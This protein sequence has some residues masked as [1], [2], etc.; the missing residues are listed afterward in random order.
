[1]NLKSWCNISGMKMNNAKLFTLTL[2]ISIIW[3]SGAIADQ[4]IKSSSLSEPKA[5]KLTSNKLNNNNRDIYIDSEDDFEGSGGRKGEVHDAL[6]NE[7]DDVDGS[8]SGDGFPGDDEDGFKPKDKNIKPDYNTNQPHHSGDGSDHGVDNDD[9]EEEEINRKKIIED[10]KPP[11]P[12]EKSDDIFFETSTETDTYPSQT[13]DEDSGTND[14]SRKTGFEYPDKKPDYEIDP[15]HRVPVSPT[16]SSSGSSDNVLIMNTSN[17]DRTT[18]FFAQPGI[19]AAVIGGAV[20]GLLFAILI[21]M[22]CVYRLRKKDEGSYALDEPQ[23]RSPQ[24]NSYTKNH[25]NREF[26][27]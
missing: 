17:E 14:N 8:G 12:T 10:Q 20:V 13:D 16:D 26:Y 5:E 11:S 24:A 1:M 23:K 7:N 9:D 21:V 19:L 22:F 25:N 18:S 3:T 27:A 4:K 2:I 15:T 6:E